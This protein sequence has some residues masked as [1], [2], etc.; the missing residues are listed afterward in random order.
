MAMKIGEVVS[1]SPVADFDRGYSQGF[2]AGVASG[3]EARAKARRALAVFAGHLE[4]IEH[5][6]LGTRCNPIHGID[7]HHLTLDHLRAASAALEALG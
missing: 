5:S 7:G 4:H 1:N 3:A 2:A 6:K